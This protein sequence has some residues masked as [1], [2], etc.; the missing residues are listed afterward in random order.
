MD[1]A[2]R[3]NM[4][5]TSLLDGITVPR[6]DAEYF[7]EG[8]RKKYPALSGPLQYFAA[9]LGNG[10]PSAERKPDE[11][12][13]KESRGRMTMI[14]TALKSMYPEYVAAHSNGKWKYQKK[15]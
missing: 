3:F 12:E 14:D 4:L 15:D 5:A 8:F 6:E 9:S 1:D 2:F 10:K 13:E 11:A 7:L